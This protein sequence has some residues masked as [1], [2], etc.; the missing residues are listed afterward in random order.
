MVHIILFIT[1]NLQHSYTK[2]LFNFN[3]WFNFNLSNPR[4]N[5]LYLNKTC[6]FSLSG[7]S[8]SIMAIHPEIENF[9]LSFIEFFEKFYLV[10][11]NCILNTS[12]IIYF[13]LITV[14]IIL[15]IIFLYANG[16][17]V[18]GTQGISQIPGAVYIPPYVYGQ[19]VPGNRMPG[20]YLG[21]GTPRPYPGV[22]GLDPGQAVPVEPHAEPVGPVKDR[23][24]RI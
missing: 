15:V 23:P 16:D 9:S 12:P 3:L 13:I 5:N 1:Y 19:P 8:L 6:N 20:R 11:L 18:P 21:I 7:S 10:I 17:P 24:M 14:F 4:I 22:S 2:R